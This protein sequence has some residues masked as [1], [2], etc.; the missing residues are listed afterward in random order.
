MRMYDIT[1]EA[2]SESRSKLECELDWLDSKL[3][4]GRL[5]LTGDCFS[6]ADLTAA[7]LLAPFARPRE[8]PVFHEMSFPD[9]LAADRPVMRWVVTQ[10][11]THRAPRNKGAELAA[12][13]PFRQ[14]AAP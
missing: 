1:P 7:S 12:A 6:R 2:A 9:A 11:H 4:D 14:F 3:S 10:Y 13:T 8:M 5:Y